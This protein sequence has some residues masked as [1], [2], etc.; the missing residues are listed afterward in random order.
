MLNIL[1]VILSILYPQGWERTC[2]VGHMVMFEDYSY[3]I[4]QSDHEAVCDIDSNPGEYADW[5]T[6]TVT[7]AHWTY[8]RYHSEYGKPYPESIVATIIAEGDILSYSAH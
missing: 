2:T 5:S 6:L 7:S 3:R 1:V 4:T 8:V